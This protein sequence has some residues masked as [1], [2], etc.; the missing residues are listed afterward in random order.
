M[1][2]SGG[3]PGQRSSGP[4]TGRLGGLPTDRSSGLPIERT[5]ARIAVAMHLTLLA[6]G[7]PMALVAAVPPVEPRRLLLAL[8]ALAAW[9]GGY[10]WVAL[11]RGLVGWLVATDLAIT[12]G[13]CLV[14]GSLVPLDRISSGSS[15]MAVLLGNSLIGAQ[16]AW[17]AWLSVPSGLLVVAAFVTGVRLA[18]SADT[19]YDQ[20]LAG[21][22]QVLGT[23]VVMVLVRKARRAADGVLAQAH[24][25]DRAATVERV[26]RA[27]ERAQL[28]LLHDTVLATLTM[29]GSGSITAS[30]RTLSARAAA[31]LA[32]VEGLLTQAGKALPGAAGGA[33]AGST[34][35][36]PLV[37]PRS[38]GPGGSG[39]PG[40][41]GESQRLDIRLAR[42]CQDAP[43]ELTVLSTLAPGEVPAAVA[44]AF[45]GAVGE[46]LRNVARHAGVGTA[47]V[48]LAEVGEVVTVRVSDEGSGFDP[49][50]V[51]AHRYGVRASVAARM[52][53]IGGRA[54]VRSAPGAG[55]QWTLEWNRG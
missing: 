41:Q 39:R 22:L 40:E 4:S 14:I 51:P 31:D 50:S 37:V 30:S 28:S 55:T 21:V 27:D 5:A 32:V 45:A 20:A 26:R 19:G 33:L 53:A 24:E 16:L 11:T 10:V 3:P 48:R 17:P 38:A 35:E 47:E 46:A 15:W 9:T 29:V 42:E 7:A 49:A 44:D 2:R 36:L 25:A 23:A 43:G 6:I 54:R 13:Y 18:G 52:A 34:G 8:A 1:D 12:A